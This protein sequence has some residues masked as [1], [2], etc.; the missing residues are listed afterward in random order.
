MAAM[1]KNP[2]NKL[3]SILAGT[4]RSV[5]IPPMKFCDFA[6]QDVQNELGATVER[7]ATA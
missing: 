2:R 5:R 7:T 6:E 4:H 3:I 1:T